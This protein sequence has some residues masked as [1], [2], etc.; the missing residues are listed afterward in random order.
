MKNPKVWINGKF[1]DIDK[2]K[3]SV[4][5]RGFL[6]GD[7]VFETMRCY[8]GIVFKLDEHL[9]RLFNSLKIM[10][11]SYPY[12]K[13]YLKKAIYKCLE[14]NRLKSA[15]IR[16]AI[17]RGE[18][19][20]GISYKDEFIPNAVIVIKD[21]EDYPDWMYSRGIRTGIVGIRQN[22]YSPLPKV[23]SLNFLTYILARFEA[24]ERGADD[25]ILTNTRGYIAEGATSNIFLIK[26]DILVTPSLDNGILPGITRE[27]IIGIAKRLKFRVRER[28]ISYRELAQASEV[29]FTNSLVEV[30][31]VTVVNSKKIG[32]GRPGNIT[33]LLH[34]SY[35]KEVIKEVLKRAP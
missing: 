32:D 16:L 22:E 28:K 17:T 5:D 33:K 30:L 15:Y 18:G 2:A 6:Y 34:I 4:F 9:A 1:F 19:R 31:P 20:F 8:A 10:R 3:I 13:R 14:T 21:F 26:R 7:G 24:K 29:F 25:A 12:S 27:V 35:Q 11:I 23:K